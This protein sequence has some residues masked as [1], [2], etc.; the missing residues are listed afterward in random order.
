MEIT[1]LKSQNSFD[2]FYINFSSLGQVTFLS[3]PTTWYAFS[4]IL[5][6][7]VFCW[8]VAG[9]VL[10]RVCEL[11]KDEEDFITL[12]LSVFPMVG[13]VTDNK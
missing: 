2:F 9:L 8:S 6:K 7:T 13:K 10:E 4:F 12:P 3:I 5:W 11:L 1:E